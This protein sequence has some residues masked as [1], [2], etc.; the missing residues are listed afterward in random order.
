LW[1]AAGGV[2]A[3]VVLAVI[4]YAAGLIPGSGSGGGGPANCTIPDAARASAPPDRTPLKNPPSDPVADG[5]TATIETAKGTIAIKLYCGSSP[6][7]AQNFVDLAAA[8]YYDGLTFHRTVANFVIQ[9]GDP[10]GD[11]TGGPG[12][13]IPDEPIVGDYHAGTVAMARTGAPNSAGSQFFIVVGDP[14]GALASV[15]TYQIF[16]EVTSGMDVV[17]QILTA[18]T[19]PGTDTPV[20]PV[21]MTKVTVQKP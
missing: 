13:T 9:G 16:G 1:L 7:A 4:A 19:E 12:Y 6:V 3:I 15:H 5:T 2:G 21:T 11:G 18:P 20:E 10:N 17:N 14:N 8:G